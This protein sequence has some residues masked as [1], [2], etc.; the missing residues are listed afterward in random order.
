MYSLPGFARRLIARLQTILNV[1]LC[2]FSDI[3]HRFLA[4]VALGDA[5]RQGGYD[6]DAATVRFLFEYDGISHGLLSPKCDHLDLFSLT[7]LVT[8]GRVHGGKAFL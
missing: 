2:C 1:E 5:T 3:C 6:R 8:R 4:S 7:R